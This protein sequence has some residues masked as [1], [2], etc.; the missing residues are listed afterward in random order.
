MGLSAEK[1]SVQYLV[2]ECKRPE[3]VEIEDRIYSTKG[4]IP[5][6]EP[7]ISC[8]TVH[9]LTGIK[10]YLLPAVSVNPFMSEFSDS[11]SIFIHVE[12]FNEVMVYGIARGKW[13]QREEFIKAVLPEERRFHFN[14]WMSVENMIIELQ[15][16]MVP[17]E[18]INK[19][20]FYLGRVEESTTVSSENDGVGQMTSVKKKIGGALMTNERAPLRVKLSPYRT[21]IELDQPESEF[22]FRIKEGL[23]VALFDSDGGQW[24]IEAIQKIKG[25]LSD[26]L[27]EI[28]I[29]A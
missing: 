3:T 18:G 9:T 19:L 4:L 1:E 27:P 14:S 2:E 21:F 25:W 23:Q 12:D 29:I 22:V 6:K 15:A 28:T 8:L 10:D 7:G 13:K 26:K 11:G 24:K 20:L 5:V 17:G 16:K